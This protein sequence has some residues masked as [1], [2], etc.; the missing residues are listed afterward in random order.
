MSVVFFIV[1]NW[2]L[3]YN[4]IKVFLFTESKNGSGVVMARKKETRAQRRKRVMRNRAIAIGALIIIIVVVVVLIV[5]GS[6]NKSAKNEKQEAQAVEETTGEAVDEEGTGTEETTEEAAANDITNEKPVNLY[7]MDYG[8]ME[9]NKV[10]HVDK[11]WTP[12]EDLESFGAFCSTQDSFPFTSEMEA[13]NELWNSIETEKDY[14]IGYELSFDVD[15]DHKVITILKPGDIETNEDL[16]NGNYPEDG[17]Y[18]DITGYMGVWV[19]DDMHQEPG[20]SYIH[21]TQ[22]EVNDNTLLTSIKLRPTPQSE[23]ISN[24]V[25]KAFTYSSEDEFDKDGH[26]IGGYASEVDFSK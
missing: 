19:Y 18:S 12:E 26:Y 20:A 10:T 14:K 15:G 3:L 24:L 16:F 25:L 13:H 17:D 9:C 11:E 1:P 8:S 5:S 22:E 4:F 7:T 21:I 2:F 6:N 23:Q